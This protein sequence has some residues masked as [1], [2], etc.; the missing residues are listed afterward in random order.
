MPLVLADY[1]DSTTA[2]ELRRILVRIVYPSESA[3]EVHT[4]LITSAT[5]GDGKTTL[6]C[7]LAIGLA[8]ANRRVLLVD[9]SMRAPR[10]EAQFGLEP[11][12]GLGEILC[13][14]VM[15]SQVYRPTE[16]PNLFV[17]G[18]DC[19]PKARLA[20]LPQEKHLT[21]SRS[22]RTHLIMSSSIPRP[23]SSCPRGNYW[24]QSSTV[25]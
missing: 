6:A 22:L 14:H 3:V 21:C 20:A 1:P 25:S 12:P 19:T 18:P 2:D 11:G 17:L 10:V 8:Q 24:R 16:F 13:S 4:F 23:L 9:V 15:P 5:K 7:N